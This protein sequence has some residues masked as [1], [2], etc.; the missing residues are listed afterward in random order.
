MNVAHAPAAQP[1]IRIEGL[2]KRFGSFTAL[3]GLDLTVA[4]GEVHGFLGP[5]GAGKSTTIR[6]LL[7]LLRAG[8]GT[9]ELLGGDPWQ[10]VVGL[11]R[12]L[13]YVPGDVVLW[14]ALS[15]GEAIDLLGNLRGG[16]DETR[17]AELVDRFE[18]DPTKRG[19][20]YSKGNR[21]K[22]AIVAA[23]A[24]RAELLILDEPTSGLDPLMEAVFQDEIAREKAQGRTVLL[25]SHILSEVEALADRV[26][27]IRQGR[28]VRTGTL[29]ELRGQTQ[30]K[31]TATLSRPPADL[32]HLPGIRDAR[33]DGARLT[34]SIDPDQLNA[35]LAALVP[36]QLSALTVAPASLED[37]FLSHYETAA[38]H[39][40]PGRPDAGH[41]RAGSALP[42][43][44]RP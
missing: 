32:G 1:A 26:S 3:D 19:R 29:R 42:R 38:D 13:A 4:R 44:A 9:V 30:V 20:Q 37:L 27:I 11:H 33:L 10:D 17:R 36:H 15:G 2:V 7:G 40:D 18:L 39:D 5:N 12:R 43:Q 24:S 23:L 25:S 31:I 6:V 21:Q 35:A 28:V 16:L 22:V 34:G 14:P 41:A 8:A